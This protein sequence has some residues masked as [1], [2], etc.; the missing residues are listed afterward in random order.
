MQQVVSTLKAIISSSQNETN[1]DKEEKEESVPSETFK[2]N[3]NIDWS[4]IQITN[5]PNKNDTNKN[6]TN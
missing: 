2:S 3:L 1:V 5:N 6:L 4:G